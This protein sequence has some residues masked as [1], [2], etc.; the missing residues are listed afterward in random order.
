M[1]ILIREMKAYR[2]SL[3]IW[4]IFVFYMVTAGM[5]KYATAY[6]SNQSLNELITQLPEAV[7][8]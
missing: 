8:E 4:C 1:N 5:W 3:I 2:K 7:R 6:S